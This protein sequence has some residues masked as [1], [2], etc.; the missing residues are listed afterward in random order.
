[1][2]DYIF[3]MTDVSK[4]HPPDKR[5]LSNIH[6]A[7]FPGAKIGVLGVN[8]SGKSSLLRIMAGVD[9]EFLGEAK[10][11]P[12]TKIGYFEQEPKLEGF[13]TDRPRGELEPE[14]RRRADELSAAIR[15]ETLDPK[16]R[17]H[18]RV[19]RSA[20]EV[21]VIVP[22]CTDI[23]DAEFVESARDAIETA[24]HVVAG[25]VVHRVELLVRPV[26]AEELYCA[27]AEAGDDCHGPARG[28]PLPFREHALRFPRD[29][30]GLTTGAGS[31]HVTARDC[32]V[33]GPHELRPRTLAH[34]FGHLLGFADGYF[35][36]YRDLGG[37]GYE[38]LEIVPD[39]EDIMTS[40]GTG[41]VHAYH[42]EALLAASDEARAAR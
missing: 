33:L 17:D 9:T 14:L 19:E 25:G 13:E 10:P 12:G 39:A 22:L 38:I 21:R 5:V 32:I 2:A 23:D 8:G 26:T 31:T 42:F 34:E 1:M 41:R 30:G 3:T 27:S 4:V 6:L 35:R 29:G 24:W 11:L 28:A 36:G 7:F 37:D 15:E 18:V 16:P 40:P 20:G